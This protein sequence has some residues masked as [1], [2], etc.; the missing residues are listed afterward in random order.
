MKKTLFLLIHVLAFAV[1]S[2]KAVNQ[3]HA[4]IVYH[5]QNSSAAANNQQQITANPLPNQI[6][7]VAQQNQPTRVSKFS[8]D[9]TAAKQLQQKSIKI[10]RTQL[11]LPYKTLQDNANMKNNYNYF[12]QFRKNSDITK[13]PDDQ[14][15]FNALPP[16]AQ[17]N[18]I[19]KHGIITKEV[20]RK[21]ARN[22]VAF[23]IIGTAIFAIYKCFGDL[24]DLFSE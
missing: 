7:P 10:Q 8:R 21:K 22:R 16:K 14:K 6:I 12:L 23:A 19:N 1:G 9:I 13:N 15:K 11:L 18:L 4:P 5:V 17:Q 24:R 2:I 3:N 20:K